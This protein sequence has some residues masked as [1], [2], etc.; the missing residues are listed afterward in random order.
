MRKWPVEIGLK[1]GNDRS[2]ATMAERPDVPGHLVWVRDV[3]AEPHPQWWADIS[4]GLDGQHEQRVV[5]H[6]PV[7]PEHAGLPL[8]DLARLYPVSLDPP[9][10]TDPA[11]A[12]P[13]PASSA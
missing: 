5:A 8:G 3:G 7:K 13:A 12:A 11:P 2:A 4:F 1:A 10:A 6:F 9:P